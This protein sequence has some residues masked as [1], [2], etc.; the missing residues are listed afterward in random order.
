MHCRK[1]ALAR[2]FLLFFEEKREKQSGAPL[3]SRC[4][5]CD[6]SL[7]EK[8]KK[9]NKIRKARISG[10]KKLKKIHKNNFITQKI[11]F[12]TPKKHKKKQQ[13]K[14]NQTSCETDHL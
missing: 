4:T 13:R 2:K 1:R 9:F 12:I 14:F 8:P 6:R 11:N 5:H 3:A 7:S 10:E